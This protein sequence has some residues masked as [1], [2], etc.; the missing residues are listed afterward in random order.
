M[1]STA[2]SRDLMEAVAAEVAV[3]IH[4]AVDYWMAQIESV[5]EDTHMTTLGRLQAVNEIVQ[6]YRR[7]HAEETMRGR[8]HAA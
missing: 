4:S 5:F 3:G 6:N 8:G 7:E 1:A 2:T